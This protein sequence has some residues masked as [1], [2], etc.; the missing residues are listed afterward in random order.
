[1]GAWMFA[2]GAL[3]GILGVFLADLFPVRLRY[4]GISFSFQVSG[5]I[6]G[7]FAPIIATVLIQ[8]SGGASW[9]VA[10]YMSVIAL[11]SLIAVCLASER[12]SVR[13]HEEAGA[14]LKVLSS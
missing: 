7:G 6:G 8:W 12:Y 4:S 11:I 5:I 14:S 3:W 9:P 13:I 10:A 2:D 1:M